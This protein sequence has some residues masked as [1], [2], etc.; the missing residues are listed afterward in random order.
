MNTK[1]KAI[2][3][4]LYV[5]LIGLSITMLVPFYWMVI[6]SLKLNKDVFSIPM[7]W[8]PETLH[9]ENYKVIWQKLPLITFFINT[10]GSE[11]R[12]TR[13]MPASV[14]VRYVCHSAPSWRPG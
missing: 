7:R 10:A 3:V 4:I 2:K 14:S 11:I 13:K 12:R 9:P 6:S 1:R 5:I 8:W